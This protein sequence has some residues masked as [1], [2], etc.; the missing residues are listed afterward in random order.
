MQRIYGQFISSHLILWPLRVVELY[1]E[2]GKSCH[3]TVR[4]MRW[5]CYHRLTYHIYLISLWLCILQAPRGYLYKVMPLLTLGCLR[6]MELHKYLRWKGDNSPSLDV[7][8]E[9]WSMKDPLQEMY[10]LMY[11]FNIDITDTNTETMR[12]SDPAGC[13]MPQRMTLSNPYL[14]LLVVKSCQT[15]YTL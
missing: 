4:A 10:W 8:E 7:W 9:K 15:I 6:E 11:F 14:S 5:W 13:N 3:A 1:K 12:T 2:E